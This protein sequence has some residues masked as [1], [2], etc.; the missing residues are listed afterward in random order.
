M[1]NM[2]WNSSGLGLEFGG[3]RQHT[4]KGGADEDPGQAFTEKGHTVAAHQERPALG[5]AAGRRDAG[6][7]RLK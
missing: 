6:A 5:V 3:Q 7:P 4:A 2:L 1:W